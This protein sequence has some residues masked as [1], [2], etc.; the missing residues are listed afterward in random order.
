MKLI[1]FTIYGNPPSKSNGYKIITLP[2]V[3]AG[4]RPRSSLAKTAKL[5]AYER[6]FFSQITGAQRLGLECKITA[7]LRV[8]NDS[9]R[10]DLDGSF[11]VI[12]D[13]L[14]RGG[15]IKNDRQIKRIVAEQFKD[16]QNPRVEIE[17]HE[18]APTL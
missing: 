6:D 2:S 3:F 4:K 13:C 18:Y 1:E 11:K 7:I 15:V 16:A 9:W 12:F 10:P 17:L 14:Q 8:Y 5:K